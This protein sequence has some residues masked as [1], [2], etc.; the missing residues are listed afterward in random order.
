M[1]DSGLNPPMIAKL[2]AESVYYSNMQ[3]CATL[4]HAGDGRQ[5][6]MLDSAF[7]SSWRRLASLCHFASGRARRQCRHVCILYATAVTVARTDARGGGA[8]SYSSC[9][10]SLS[11]HALSL[12]DCPTHCEASHHVKRIHGITIYFTTLWSPVTPVAPVTVTYQLL[13][14][15]AWVA[16]CLISVVILSS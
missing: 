14:A 2:P 9:H 15:L 12:A 7:T 8:T 13:S 11:G 6:N 1:N 5:L 10:L 3:A 16:T 4:W